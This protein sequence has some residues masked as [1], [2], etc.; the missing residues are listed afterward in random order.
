MLRVYCLPRERVYRD[1]AKK[2]SFSADWP[3]STELMRD[4]MKKI[5]SPTYIMIE[6]KG[7]YI[8]GLWGQLLRLYFLAGQPNIKRNILR[9]LNGMKVKFS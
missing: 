4:S 6:Q 2:G 8:F 9:I 3:L 7:T 1:I 5:N